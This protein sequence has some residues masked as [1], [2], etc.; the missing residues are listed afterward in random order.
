MK[1]RVQRSLTLKS[2]LVFFLITLC[3]FAIFLSIQFT[4]LLE[5]RKN[6]YL[7]QL[8][9]AALQIQKPLTDALLSSDLNEAKSLLISLKTSGIMGQAT[10]I[11][12]EN[13]R[14]MRLNFA[15]PK[16]IPGWAKSVF[17]IPVEMTLPLYAYGNAALTSKPFGY[18]ILQVDSNRVY[19]YALNT[20]G[21]IITTYLLLTLIVA[22][23]AT[24]FMSRFIVR[25]LRR[26]ALDLNG[27]KIVNQV[28]VAEHHNDDELGLLAKGYNNQINKQIN[29]QKLD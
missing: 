5:Q 28:V 14:V 21:L 13:V 4:Y 2:L 20:L 15:T 1:T 7:N 12:H 29:S 22:V 27:N 25:P 24:W 8:S 3:S 23:A 17:D 11:R 19:H 16:P 6:D 10:L 18:L 9:N 26:I